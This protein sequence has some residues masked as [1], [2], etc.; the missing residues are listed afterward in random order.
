MRRV[1]VQ[2]LAKRIESLSADEPRYEASHELRPARSIR[3]VLVRSRLSASTPSLVVCVMRD[4][5]CALSFSGRQI[6][7]TYYLNCA[8]RPSEGRGLQPSPS[9][10]T[11]DRMYCSLPRAWCTF[12]VVL[13]PY[14]LIMCYDPQ[15][16]RHI[17]LYA[18][19]DVK[20]DHGVPWRQIRRRACSCM[21]CRR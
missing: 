3:H 6:I 18:L 20:G 14:L 8:A 9:S 12:M 5:R 2:R 13:S 19:P 1:L 4:E 7:Y 10:V 21:A 17:K 15:M 11:D 16:A